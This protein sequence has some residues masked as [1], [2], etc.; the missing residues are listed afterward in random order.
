MVENRN[1]AMLQINENPVQVAHV[2][3]KEFAAKYR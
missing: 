1:E 2:S 3:S